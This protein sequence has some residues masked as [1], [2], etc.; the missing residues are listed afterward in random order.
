MKSRGH[1]TSAEKEKELIDS[2]QKNLEIINKKSKF[3]IVY[4]Y[5][6][7]FNC[8]Y[9][10]EN[11]VKYQD[12][13][14]NQKLDYIF[15]SILEIISINKTIENEIVLFGGEPLLEGNRELIFHTMEFA[16]ENNIKISII[17]NGSNLF[18]YS[19]LI[20]DFKEIISGFSITIDGS[21]SEHDKRRTYRNGKGS[22]DEILKGINFILDNK[23]NLSIRMNIDK[24]MMN[25]F[26]QAFQDLRERLNLEP[27][28]YLSLVED[29]TCT[30]SCNSAYSYREVSEVLMKNAYFEE[31][32]NITLNMKPIN[33]I[34][35]LLNKNNLIMPRFKFC[36]M[37][38]LYIFTP[39]GKICVCP[40]SC[41][42]EEFQVG[43][44]Y[45]N[46]NID[47]VK[48]HEKHV[49]SSLAIDMCKS[50]E[51]APLCGGGCYVRRAYNT[52]NFDKGI[53]YY[54]D[55]K[56]TLEYFLE[57]MVLKNEK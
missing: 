18:N 53:C 37:S 51:L 31:N 23:F 4:S 12:K 39:D 49:Y 8:F 52:Q 27:N 5:A 13:I 1:I 2:Y 32:S 14:S 10:F 11:D 56:D 38:E 40:Q 48:I 28:I 50:C 22:Y 24:T 54:K 33:Q 21:K 30:G 36:R 25:D 15:K 47:S 29:S 17:T 34:I 46:I 26:Q 16:K 55:I 20:L 9:C 3:Y 41:Q 42:N 19:E 57:E 35:A 44:F 45:P 43:E 6:C 7:N